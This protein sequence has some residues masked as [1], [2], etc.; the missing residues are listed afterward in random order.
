[1]PLPRNPQICTEL[2]KKRPKRGSPDLSQENI[3]SCLSLGADHLTYANFW[4]VFW[5]HFL[6]R[7]S[8]YA[9]V[10]VVSMLVVNPIIDILR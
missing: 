1:M 4:N 2:E 5:L 9:K 6:V 7:N 3:L 10:L 8:D